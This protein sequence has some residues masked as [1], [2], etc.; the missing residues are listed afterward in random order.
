MTGTTQRVPAR[1]RITARALAPVAAMVLALPGASAQDKPEV[2]FDWSVSCDAALYCVART[3]GQSDA[4]DQMTFKLERSNKPDGKLFVITGPKGPELAVGMRVDIDVPDRDYGA[5]G[6]IE[7]VYSGN[8][9]AFSGTADRPL[10]QNLRAGTAGLVTIDFGAASGK[11]QYKVSLTGVTS[12]LAHMD[13]V[14]GRAERQDAAVLVGGLPSGGTVTEKKTDEP[15]APEPKT[16]SAPASQPDKDSDVSNANRAEAIEAAGLGG[17]ELVAFTAVPGPIQM[18]AYR[19]FGCDGA[20]METGPH[21]RVEIA[22]AE[23]FYFVRCFFTGEGTDYAVFRYEDGNPTDA[24]YYTFEPPPDAEGDSAQTVQNPVWNKVSWELT[25]TY[26]YN[27]VGK[28]CG[29]YSRYA[30][31]PAD[32]WFELHEQ[33]EKVTCDGVVEAP[34]NWPMDWTI[35]E[36]GG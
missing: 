17:V 26:F 1:A 20:T 27:P 33:R 18:H 32:D 29:E 8:E 4:G 22:P 7:K 5:Y 36:M 12:V 16:A 6:S 21:Q 23:S 25:A 34:V 11:I 30:Y 2:F 31:L 3:D 15:A 10:I 14:Q 24:G 35:D 28:D 9:M 19:V 13:R